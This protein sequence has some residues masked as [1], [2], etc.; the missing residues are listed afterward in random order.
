MDNS[1]DDFICG[2]TVEDLFENGEISAEYLLA[3]QEELICG[4]VPQ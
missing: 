3:M 4:N 2:R 1:L